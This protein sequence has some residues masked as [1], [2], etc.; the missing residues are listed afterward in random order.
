M[1]LTS[2]SDGAS[3]GILDELEVI[4]LGLQEPAL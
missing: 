2:S 4:D 1:R 3:E